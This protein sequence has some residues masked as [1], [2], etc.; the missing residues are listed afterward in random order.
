MGTLSIALE[1]NKPTPHPGEFNTG[2]L[3]VA[4]G[5]MF[6]GTDNYGDVWSANI[7]GQLDCGSG[8]FVGSLTNG[9]AH[10]FGIDAATIMLDGSLSATYQPSANPV[11]LVNGSISLSSP[12]VANTTGMG[13]W[14]AALQ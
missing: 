13:T 1:A 10:I 12:Q 7:S 5:A 6:S 3:T 14:S 8:M 4:P 2:T 9:V 11:A